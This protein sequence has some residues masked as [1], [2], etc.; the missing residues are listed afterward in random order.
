VSD[1]ALRRLGAQHLVGEPLAGP[2]EVVRWL[3]AVQ[4][5]DYGAAKWALALRSR[6][7]SDLELER[8]VD[9]GLILRTHILRPTWHFVLP[10][11]IRWLAELTGP[12]VRRSLAGRYRQLDIDETLIERS[13]AAVAGAL[14]GGRHLTRPE[15]GDV[16]VSAGIQAHGQ[17][18]PH[19][20]MAAE[21]DG[22]ITSGPRRGKEFTFALLAERAPNARRLE[23]G[24]A[25]RELVL[26]FFR[27][28]GPAQVN[29]FTWWSGLTAAE[30]RTG[31]EAAGAA[32]ERE[33]VDG[34][35]YYWVG[36][37]F[38]TPRLASPTAHLLPNFDEYTVAYRDRD[39]LYV[40]GPFDRS[41]FSF[42]SVLANVVTIDGLVRGAWR[43]TFASRHVRLELR[44][45]RDL[46]LTEQRA[47][48]TAGQKLA[49]FLGTSV[50]LVW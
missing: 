4:S 34:K 1:I 2:V 21:L 23:H 24:D 26:R 49:Y 32:L 44:L 3:G 43:R 19:L 50:E 48:E 16:L 46:H 17:R 33:V 13:N 29:D 9:A 39:Q 35:M 6:P 20:I 36:L 15:I 41:V 42:G 40:D 11:D 10:E 22:L 31:L 47:V 14:R 45:L 5:Q 28:H 7:S 12:R 18:L 38:A 37:E 8:I 27:S 30:A 25:L